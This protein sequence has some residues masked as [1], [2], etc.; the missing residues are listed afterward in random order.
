LLLTSSPQRD[1][2]RHFAIHC[3]SIT[4]QQS[5]DL[6]PH[7]LLHLWQQTF[8]TSNRLAMNGQVLKMYNIPD[9][10]IDQV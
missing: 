2:E 7:S 10:Q 3:C 5:V 4:W 6:F 9:D 1:T 8:A